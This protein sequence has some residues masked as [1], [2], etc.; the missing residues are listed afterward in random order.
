[1][2]DNRFEEL[3]KQIGREIMAELLAEGITEYPAVC[4]QCHGKGCPG[5]DGLGT[6]VLAIA[7]GPG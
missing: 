1:M 5:C 2:H 7:P 4:W 3:D 6:Y